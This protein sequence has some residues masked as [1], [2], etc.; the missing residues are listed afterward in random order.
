MNKGLKK[1]VIMTDQHKS[2][3]PWL[4]YLTSNNVRHKF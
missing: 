3:V 1:C 4:L 2:R